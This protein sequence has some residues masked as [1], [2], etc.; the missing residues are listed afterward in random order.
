MRKSRLYKRRPPDRSIPKYRAN[1]QIMALKM[2][3]I[4]D[5][6]NDLGILSRTEALRLAK[7]RGVDLVEVSPL[8]NPPVVKLVDFGKLQYQQE[9]LAKKQKLIQKKGGI[10]GIRLSLRIGDHDREVRENQAKQFLADEQK[11]RI[12]MILKG[13]ERQYMRN[14]RESMENFVKKLG[15]GIKTETPF[16]NQGGRLSILISKT[17]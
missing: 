11:V 10:K 5:Q 14:A 13:R 6:G 12:E 16:S 7:E 17:K 3:V 15:E 4:D 1:E 9:K 2:L 8:A